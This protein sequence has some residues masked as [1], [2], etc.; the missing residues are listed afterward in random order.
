MDYSLLPQVG[1]RGGLMMLDLPKGDVANVLLLLLLQ[2]SILILLPSCSFL[3][4]G[5]LSMPP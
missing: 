2:S 1:L 4:Y 3:G 5:L